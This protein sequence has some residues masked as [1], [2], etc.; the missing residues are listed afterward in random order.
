ML[1]DGSYELKVPFSDDRELIMD[2]LKYGSDCEVVSSE[3]PQEKMAA[4]ISQAGMRYQTRGQELA[5]ASSGWRNA[6]LNLLPRD[7]R[8][9][10]APERPGPRLSPAGAQAPAAGRSRRSGQ[11]RNDAMPN[12]RREKKSPHAAGSLVLVPAGFIRFAPRFA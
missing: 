6:F 12:R 10:D 1:E 3:T 11:R 9:Q 2:I 4:E 8:H 7:I 5:D